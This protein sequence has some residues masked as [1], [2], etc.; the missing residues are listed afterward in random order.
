[1][2]LSNVH[3]WLNPYVSARTAR[4]TTRALG[5]VVCRTTPMSMKEPPS[6][7]RRRSASDDRVVR[8]RPT[9]AIERPPVA[10]LA[11]LVQVQLAHDQLRLVRVAHLTDELPLG[12]D[13]VAL[14]VEVVVAERLDAD[15][16]D[17]AHVVHVGHGR[18][19]LL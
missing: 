1:M 19:G 2:W 7:C 8:V 17:R 11:D 6:P 9:V 5:G 15:P 14:P 13:E 16:I 12:V 4:S 3:T 18:R 10:D